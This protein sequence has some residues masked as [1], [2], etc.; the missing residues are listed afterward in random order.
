M[1]EPAALV[2]RIQIDEAAF[3]RFLLGKP[4]KLLAQCIDTALDQQHRSY[5]VFRY[6]KAAQAVFAFFYFHHGNAESLRQSDE[7]AVLKALAP[8]AAPGAAGHILCCLNAWDLASDVC[9]RFA[10]VD[11]QCVDQPSAPDAPWPPG[12]RQD[13]DKYFYRETETDFALNFAKGRIVDKSIVRRC[14]K[15]AEARRLRQVVDQLHLA[16]FA[17]PLRFFGDY[18]FNGEFVYLQ[19][20]RTTPL[21]GIDPRTFGPTP[22]GGADAQHAVVGCQVRRVEVATFKALQKGETLY[23]KDRHQ[24]FDAHLAPLPEADAASFRVLS[25][26]DVQDSRFLYFAGQRLAKASLGAFRFEPTGYF[27]QEKLLLAENAVY[28]GSERVSVDPATFE[29][30]RAVEDLTAGI[31][32]TFLY[33]VR[34]RQGLGVLYR[35]LTPQG[36]HGPAHLVRTDD[37]ERT[38]AEVQRQRVEAQEAAHCFPPG[39]GDDGP[40]GYAER[41]RAWAAQHFDTACARYKYHAGSLLYGPI[42]DF[43]RAAFDEKGHA[44]VLALYERIRSTAWLNPHLFHH[45]ARCFVALGQH[46]AAMAEVRKA[47]VFGHT[48][49]GLLWQDDDLRPLWGDARFQAWRVEFGDGD[50]G[51]EAQPELLAAIDELPPEA[52]ENGHG[53]C[54]LLLR[55][56][57]RFRFGEPNATDSEGAARL[58]RI[59]RHRLRTAHAFYEDKAFYVRH[60]DHPLLHP[61][62]HFEML[63]RQFNE[64]HA[65]GG[66]I[67]PQAMARAQATLNRLRRAVVEITDPGVRQDVDE[68]VARN[69][70]LRHVLSLDNA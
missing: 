21:P 63:Q 58:R 61:L 23:H 43:F 6:L 57:C 60:V 30:V 64:A 11:Q 45:T 39:V 16:T 42:H 49:L 12:W 52:F 3:K 36:G 44:E 35:E 69:P 9:A 19:S 8:F 55:L 47:C 50:T 29:V 26:H 32:F 28:I 40:A 18:F 70:F 59:F 7:L 66:S 5:H 20:G 56:A 68:E 17:Q 34:D 33:I 67:V 13:C 4:A 65:Y 37:A 38:L 14:A 1:S 10:I 2:A 24:V 25:E 46:E 48:A 62:V 41:F 22:Y 54:D 53:L 31:A 27:H 51:A 15:L